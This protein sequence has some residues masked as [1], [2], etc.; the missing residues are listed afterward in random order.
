MRAVSRNWAFLRELGLV[1]TRRIGRQVNATVLREDGSREAY[2]HPGRK[3]RARYFQLPY[4][5]WQDGW[6]ERLELPGKAM[7]LTALTLGDL[8]WLPARHAP[9]WY[10]ISPSMLE[11]GLRELRH[12]NLLGVARQPKTAALAP[13][14]YTVENYYVLQPPFGPKGERAAGAPDTV[15]VTR[16]GAIKRAAAKATT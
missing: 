1:E 5:Y 2:S 12:A 4:A 14:G 13:E 8:F 6:H 11:R 7:L 3:P 15:T 9:A 16:S 10:G